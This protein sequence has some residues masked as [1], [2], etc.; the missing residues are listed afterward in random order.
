MKILTRLSFPPGD[1]VH[2]TVRLFAKFPDCIFVEAIR[3]IDPATAKNERRALISHYGRK[4]DSLGPVQP[5]R[6][7]F[8]LEIATWGND[9]SGYRFR[10]Y[11]HSV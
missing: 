9:Y 5:R 6:T 8:G 4:V 1:N 10:R 2:F 11:R 7:P 3:D